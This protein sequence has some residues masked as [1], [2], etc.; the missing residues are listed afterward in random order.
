MWIYILPPRLCGGSVVGSHPKTLPYEFKVMGSSLDLLH[1][2]LKAFT[3]TI[4]IDWM[5]SIVFSDY[6]LYHV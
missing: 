1:Y 6:L 3:V 4:I 2:C 5:T